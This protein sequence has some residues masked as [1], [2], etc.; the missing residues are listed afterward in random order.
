MK[1]IFLYTIVH[2]SMFL[3]FSSQTIWA[4]GSDC[5]GAEP[6]CDNVLNPFAAG[7]NQPNAPV[8]NNYDCLFTQPNPAWYTM[9]IGQSGDI[10]FTLD[11]TNNVDIDFIVWGPFASIA[12]ANAGCGNLGNGGA[13]GSVVDCSYSAVAQEDVFIPNAV[14]GEVYIL[15]I[16]NFSNLPTDIFSTANTGDGSVV[17]DCEVNFTYDPLPTGLNDGLMLDTTGSSATFIVCPPDPNTASSYT[18]GF[19]IGVGGQN[20]ADTIEFFNSDV[21]TVFASSLVFAPPPSAPFDTND[22]LIQVTPDETNIGFN[23]F[24]VGVLNNS[25]AGGCVQNFSIS[26][27][28]PGIEASADDTVLCPLI[29]DTTQLFGA[30]Y[31]DSFNL[32]AQNFQWNLISGTATFSDDTLQNPLLYVPNTLTPGDSVVVAVEYSVDLPG[33]GTT[34]LHSDTIKFRVS[35]ID[36]TTTAQS[37]IC[38]GESALIEAEFTTNNLGGLGGACGLNTTGCAG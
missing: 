20:A 9:T 17:C 38:V 27:L 19:N 1:K 16:T 24:S 30:T 10:D 23:Q 7:T 29:A 18:L 4:Q 14:A 28:V 33:S 12:D 8:G 21:S 11:N 15:L 32:Q 25:A 35:D 37:P 2:L 26:V 22:V 34:C 3:G 31:A 13:G 5:L 36:L 6:F